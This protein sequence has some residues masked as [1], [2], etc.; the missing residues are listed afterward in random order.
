MLPCEPPD[1]HPKKPRFAMPANA[2]DTHVHVFG[3]F[4][5]WPLSADRSYTPAVCSY[6]DLRKLHAR[7]GVTRAVVVHG[8]ANGL[9]NSVT[10]DAV[11]REPDKLRGV[12]VIGPDVPVSRLKELHRQGIRG[13][14]LSTVIRNGIGL[15]HLDG[16]LRLAGSMNWHLLIHLRNCHEL[17]VI[18]ETLERSSTRIVLDHLARITPADAE[19]ASVMDCVRR[20]LD[21]GRVWLKLA[22]LYRSSRESHPYADMLPII[23]RFVQERPDRLIWGTNWPHPICPVAM[24]N[25]GDLVDLIPQWLPDEDAQQLVLVDNPGMLYEFDS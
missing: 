12:V 23:S 11:G 17:P 5:R 7:L 10:L 3:P 2:C 4:D 6:E 8:G 13:C 18:A 20:L 25:D 21:T 24:P 1:P 14:R 9:D 16:M 19:D 15:E 22:S